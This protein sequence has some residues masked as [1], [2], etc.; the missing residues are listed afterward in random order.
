MKNIS[1]E[2]V[3]AQRAVVEK[4]LPK[5]RGYSFMQIPTQL[6]HGASIDALW[7]GLTLKDEDV[8]VLLDIDAIPLR[9]DAL[10]SYV[11]RASQGELV[12]NAQTSEHIKNSGVFAAPST[13]AMSYGTYKKMDEP[14]AEP[15]NSNDV[16]EWYTKWASV[17]VVPVTFMLPNRYSDPVH[18]FAGEELLQ[19]YWQLPNG[20]PKYGLGTYY[21]DT[22]AE[23]IYHQFQIRLPENHKRFIKKCEEVLSGT[24]DTTT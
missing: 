5:G 23:I 11:W 16:C 14:S 22:Q 6:S 20:G 1:D 13:L 9:T 2:V 4:F 18:R 7:G 15:D 8:V 19:P 21:R 12:G 17:C 3:Q 10:P 24:K